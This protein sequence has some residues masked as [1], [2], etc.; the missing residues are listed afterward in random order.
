[1]LFLR[2]KEVEALLSVEEA[3]EA[4]ERVHRLEA[5]G[6]AEAKPRAR[7]RSGKTILHALPA[8]MPGYLGVKTYVTGPFGARFHYLLYD[9]EGKPLALME[10]DALGRIRTG[11]ATGLATRYL[12][13]KAHTLALL[14]SGHQARTQLLGVLGA[15]PLK[16]VQVY[17]PTPAHRE[18]FAQRMAEELG[19][20]VQAV[21]R[22]EAA[23]EG[24]QVVVTVTTAKEPFLKG[25]WLEE[26]VH[27]N[28]VGSNWAHRRELDAE[29]I[30]KAELILV[31][32]EAQARLEAGDLI[33]AEGE[34][35]EVWPKVRPLKD[36]VT[37]GVGRPS[38]KAITLFK[39][40]GIGL[41]DLALAALAY[42]KAQA[43]GIGQKVEV[44]PS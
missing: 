32:L 39:S 7:P 9:E 41:W 2:E 11:A 8:A 19:L 18:A 30:R 21:D 35:V 36:L 22:P 20:E 27:V 33:L 13:P 23:L 29:A 24:A 31:D 28:A 12:S 40:V 4:L 43:L 42:E 37:G 17:S 26:G 10:A 34:G 1:M 44:F 5:S 15:C 6:L 16:R 38:P 25:A 3:I 14:G